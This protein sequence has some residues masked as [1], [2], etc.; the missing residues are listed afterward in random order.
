MRI[1]TGLAALAA[2]LVLGGAQE[3]PA[4]QDGQDGQV[5]VVAPDDVGIDTSGPVPRLRGGE[6]AFERSGTLMSGIAS[7]EAMQRIPSSGAGTGLRFGFSV[8]LP[9][10]SLEGAVQ[11]MA[12]DR[13]N[14]PNPTQRCG[15]L[16]LEA[17]AGKISGRRS[18]QLVSQKIGTSHST[19]SLRLS[20]GYDKRALKININGEEQTDG[21]AEGARVPR[22]ATYR[23]QVNVHRVGDCDKA[24]AARLRT[25]DEAAD[26]LF[27]P[28]ADGSGL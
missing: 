22:P 13:S 7:N 10:D 15:Q 12:G 5:V 9:D 16:R 3:R 27:I 6:W 25:L 23:W 19:L 21:L 20:G 8:C 24:P 14:M 17:K 4:G 2:A 1:A 28:G 11:Q 26:L 18:C